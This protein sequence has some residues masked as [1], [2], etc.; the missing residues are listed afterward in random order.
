MINLHIA[1]GYKYLYLPDALFHMDNRRFSGFQRYD[2]KKDASRILITN[3][4]SLSITLQFHSKEAFY[5]AKIFNY[6]ISASMSSLRLTLRKEKITI[7]FLGENAL[8]LL[9]IIISI[10]LLICRAKCSCNW[11]TDRILTSLLSPP[12]P[13]ALMMNWSLVV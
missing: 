8:I 9:I 1:L 5:S 10:P 11:I 12:E 6:W 13:F 4:Q 7:P 2:L 3:C